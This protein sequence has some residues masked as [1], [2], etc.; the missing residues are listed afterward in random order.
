MRKTKLELSDLFGDILDEMLPILEHYQT[1]TGKLAAKLDC[2]VKNIKFQKGCE[3]CEDDNFVLER[4]RILIKLLYNIAINFRRERISKAIIHRLAY[5]FN[6]S[7]DEAAKV[8]RLA[9]RRHSGLFSEQN[10]IDFGMDMLIDDFLRKSK[11]IIKKS[12]QESNLISSDRT[13]RRCVI[14]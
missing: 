1:K 6:I 4:K 10:F 14:Q 5:H 7:N 8:G 12:D 13:G 2:L 9:V 3:T 11:K